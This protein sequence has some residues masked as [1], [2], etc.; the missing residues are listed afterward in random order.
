MST[1]TLQAQGRRSTVAIPERTEAHRECRPGAKIKHIAPYARGA[2][3]IGK[4]DGETH[5]HLGTS[6]SRNRGPTPGRQISL[7]T[8]MRI[9]DQEFLLPSGATDHLQQVNRPKQATC[10]GISIRP[11]SIS[12]KSTLLQIQTRPMPK[13]KPEKETSER[14]PVHGKPKGPAT[15]KPVLMPTE[16]SSVSPSGREHIT[17]NAKVLPEELTRSLSG[18]E[19]ITYNAKY[20]LRSLHAYSQAGSILHI[21]QGTA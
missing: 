9:Q 8:A 14:R 3:V 7:I 1:H 11:L 21:M 4:A 2:K 13:K 20:C 17:Y 16:A 10:L 6:M 15:D 19:H 18:R 5:Q 12:G